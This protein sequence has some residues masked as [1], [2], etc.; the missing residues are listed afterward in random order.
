MKNLK[1]KIALVTGAVELLDHDFNLSKLEAELS[2]CWKRRTDCQ[3]DFKAISRSLT[4]IRKRRSLVRDDTITP[5]R[6]GLRSS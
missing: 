5:D 3:Q 6:P 2:R 1:D 4:V